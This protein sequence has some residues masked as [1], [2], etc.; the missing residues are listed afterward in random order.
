MRRRWA[1]IA[2]VL[3]AIVVVSVMVTQAQRERGRRTAEPTLSVEDYTPRST[4]VVD[5]NP[6]PRARFPVVDVHS[7]H[8]PGF[9]AR[10]LDRIALALIPAVDRSPFPGP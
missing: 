10:R 6:V 7:H 9:T 2:G 5:A 4:L 3:L 1:S 8:W